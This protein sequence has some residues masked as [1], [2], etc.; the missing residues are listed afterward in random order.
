MADPGVVRTVTVLPPSARGEARVVLRAAAA[1]VFGALF[2]IGLHAGDGGMASG[3][4][5]LAP[6]QVLFRDAAPPVQRLYREL[7]EGLIEAENVRAA[8]KSWPAVGALAAQGIPPFAPE[9][10]EYDWRL[11]RD[12]VFLN[13]VGAPSTPGVG[14]ALLALIQEPE[15]GSGESAAAAPLD[16]IHHRLADG[17]VLHV[18]VWFRADG[19]AAADQPILTQPYTT[20]WTQVLVGRQGP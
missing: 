6:F 13:Y 20:G 7:Q 19:L 12:G 10:P 14:P 9:R 3:R 15:P 1:I 8:S 18:T 2:V 16:E 11:V 4:G 17:T 5:D